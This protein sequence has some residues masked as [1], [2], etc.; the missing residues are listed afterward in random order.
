MKQR[1][2][3][4]AY[5]VINK[6]S[7][8]EMPVKTA[9]KVFKLHKVLQSHFEFQVESEDRIVSQAGVAVSDG[10]VINFDNQEQYEAVKKLLDELG[11]MDVDFE[12]TI[13]IPLEEFGNCSL[14]PADMQALEPFI[15]SE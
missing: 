10:G 13:K 6:I 8:T 9:Y 3:I 12:C 11:D 5:K 1:D 7:G 2:I 4:Q 15:E 14:S